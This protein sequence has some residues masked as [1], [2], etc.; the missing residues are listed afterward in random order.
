MQA[1][2]KRNIREGAE[3][4]KHFPGNSLRN[5]DTTMHDM[6]SVF[7]TISAMEKVVKLSLDDTKSIAPELQGKDLKDTCNKVWDW[8][9]NHFQYNLDTPGVEELRTPARSWEN[10]GYKA[11]KGEGID[12]DDFSILVSSI[13]THLQIGHS[14]RMAKYNGKNYFQHIYVVVPS[15]KGANMNYGGDYYT[16]DPV[17]DRFNYEV[18]FSEKHDRVMMPIRMLAGLGDL[19]NMPIMMLSGIEN[20]YS[21]GNEFSGIGSFSGLGNIEPTPELVAA[22]FL[23]RTKIHLK[24][25]YDEIKANPKVIAGGEKYKLWLE[26]LL[27]NFDDAQKRDAALTELEK[28]EDQQGLSG[29]SGLGGFFSSIKKGV[30]SVGKAVNNSA[31]AV[32][33][34]GKFVGKK[35]GQAAKF[36]GQKTA[37]AA[38]AVANTAKDVGKFILKV[39]PVS[40]GIRAALRLAMKINLFRQ[41]ERIGYGYWTEQQAVS[42]GMNAVEWRKVKDKLTKVENTY[43]SLQGDPAE[44]KKNIIAGWEKGTK[45]HGLLRGFEGFEGVGS[46]GVEPVTAT[47]G[48]AAASGVLVKIAT[49]LKDVDWGKLFSGVKSIV[50]PNYSGQDDIPENYKYPETEEAFESNAAYY[51]Q[52]PA[53]AANSDNTKNMIMIGGGALV[54]IVLLKKVL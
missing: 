32:A 27:E 33:Q 7:D 53:V 46:L 39:N 29:L 42:K 8:C 3:Y 16:I 47:A 48:T 1:S 30:R 45:K 40:V 4:F 52:P 18:K 49:M 15:K 12:C 35:T 43:K 10:R 38:K 24:N 5:K 25:T 2:S 26:Y 28:I 36:V 14:F 37:Q 23:M 22:D 13:L 44:L 11:G 50:K 19:G 51:S 34:A 6:G 9:Y 41:A 54:A 17:V 31:K 21:Y 20:S